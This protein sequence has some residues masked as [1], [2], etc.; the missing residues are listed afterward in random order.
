MKIE[1]GSQAL[2]GEALLLPYSTQDVATLQHLPWL[3]TKLCVASRPPLRFGLPG[4][5]QDE[6]SGY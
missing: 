3:M 6:G 1:T 2:V 5:S 4:L